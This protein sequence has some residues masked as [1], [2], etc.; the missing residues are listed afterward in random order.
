MVIGFGGEKKSWGLIGGSIEEGE[1]LLETLSR[2]IREE[3]NMEVLKAIPI[4]YQQ[5]TNMKTGESFYQLRYAA[6]VE[7]YGPF[8]IDEGDGMSEKGITEIKLI[9]ADDYRQYFDWG[10]IGER[11]IRRAIELKDKLNS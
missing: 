5:V 9:D 8:V 6:E 3:S 7:P 11:I 2:E 10:D 1:A 4:G